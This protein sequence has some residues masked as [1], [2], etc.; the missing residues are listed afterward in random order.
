MYYCLNTYTLL[1]SIK[2]NT[3]TILALSSHTQIIVFYISFN[4]QSQYK[5][6][7]V[8]YNTTANE[9]IQLLLNC[10]NL[11]EDPRHYCIHEVCR[12]SSVDRRVDPNQRPV[13]LQALWPKEARSLWSFVLRRNVN[14]AL[15]MKSRVSNVINPFDL[16]LMFRKL[17]ILICLT[18]MSFFILLFIF[19]LFF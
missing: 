14:Y 11:N 13:L 1:S 5:S 18:K 4:L 3:S 15:N 19:F 10:Y 2:C 7:M 6:L 8:S 17:F 12:S 9:L 16:F